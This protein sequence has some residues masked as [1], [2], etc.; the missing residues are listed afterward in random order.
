MD[1]HRFSTRGR[2]SA[3]LLVAGAMVKPWEAL[4]QDATPEASP[5]VLGEAIKSQTREE[6]RAELNEAMGY[7]EAATPGGTFIDSAT[8]DIQTVQPFLAEEAASL[9]VVGLIYEG[10]T[11]GDPRTGQP[12]PG[13]LSDSWE[14]AEDGR[15]YTFHLNQNVKWH[16][17]TP[18]TAADVQFSADAL[19]S[20][21]SGSVYTGSFVDTVESWRV[22]D[23]YTFEMVAKEPKYTFL[24]DIQ[25]LFVVPKHIWEDVPFAD[26]RTD[27]GATGADPSRVVGTGPFKFQEWKQGESVTLVRN[28]DYY[29]K[30]PY[31]DSYVLRIWPDQT[32]VVNAL[33]NGELDVAGLEPSD[34]AA[35]EGTSGVNVAHYPTRGFTYYEFNL[36]PEVTT[37]WQDERVRQALLYALDRDSIVNDILLGY[38]EVAQG[39]QPVVSYAYA[40]DQIATKYT[41]DPEKAKSLLAEA[42]WTD[43]DGDGI[44]DKDGE[45]LSFEFLYPS[46]SPT[47]DQ[48]VAYIQDA[49]NAIGVNGTPRS[50]EFPALIEATTTNPT[51]DVAMYG[52]SWDASFIQDAMFG[53]DQYQVGFNDMKYCNP[54]LD[55]INDQAKRTFDEAERRDLLI[56]ASNI[57]N[58]EQPIA[59]LHFSQ[60]HAAFNDALQNYKP[61]TWGV[62]LNQVWIQQ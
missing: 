54:E 55:E 21:D 32:S 24:Y 34:I 20:P 62:D 15:T 13:G 40:P 19:A 53:C 46:G 10:L 59:V 38:A 37:K 28:D 3:M 17:G 27:P 8:S 58:D 7:T 50:L 18:F 39:T 42:G 26:W 12:A 47:S 44:L 35:V 61:S 48:I 22:I 49:W 52:F 31:I 56:E 16:D 6:F 29:D 57:V 4:A 1:K 11:G 41:Y 23:D 2:L 25:T 5:V 14:I 9:G 30:V 45:A 36:D 60:A 33:L 51:F 43:S